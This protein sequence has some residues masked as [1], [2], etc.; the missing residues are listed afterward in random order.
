MACPRLSGGV[1]GGR[2]LAPWLIGS[3]WQLAV[4]TLA[5]LW[6]WSVAGAAADEP[7]AKSVPGLAPAGGEKPAESDPLVYPDPE[8][9][10]QTSMFGVSAVGFKFVYVLDRSTSMGGAGDAALKAVKA[11]LRRSLEP[12]DTVHQFQI[13]F[14]NEKPAIFNPSGVPG[15]LAFA[16]RANKDRAVR[17]I[18]SITADG[19]T[20]HDEALKL[21]VK[22]RPDVIFFLT[23]GDEPKLTRRELETIHR[24]ANGITIHAI[25]FGPG[26]KPEEQ[27][28][29]ATLAEEN[30]GKYAY[31]DL[32]KHRTGAERDRSVPSQ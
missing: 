30:G 1:M 10:A 31:V 17:F 19:N 9:R 32:S 24:M 8:G 21:A 13:I 25:E 26:P 2:S 6:C 16:N 12:L 3:P 22:L 29:L 15:R 28:F 14:Y 20:R 18:E 23:D 5:A 11:E 27:S 7:L 4:V